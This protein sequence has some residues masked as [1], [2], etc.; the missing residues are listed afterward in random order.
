MKALVLALAAGAMLAACG[1]KS[2]QVS[3]SDVEK[4]SPADYYTGA[5]GIE[6]MAVRRDINV[7]GLNMDPN[8]AT[9]VGTDR[10]FFG[11]DSSALTDAG[12]ATLQ[13]TAA[14]LKKSGKSAVV[15][16]HADERGTREYNLALGDRRAVSVKKYL[17]G[18]GVDA[19]K[20]TTVSYGKERPAVEGNTETAW[21]QNRRAVLVTN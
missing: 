14:Y 3:V 21:S 8:L 17:V 4:V 11:Y 15:E 20:L 7:G 10:V 5:D 19:S 1:Q 2:H 16:G 12:Q 6:T 18:L 9:N 13:Q